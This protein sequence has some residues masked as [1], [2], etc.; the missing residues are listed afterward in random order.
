MRHPLALAAAR[1]V[2]ERLRQDGTELQRGLNLR[3]TAF[4]NRLN[5]IADEMQAPV[6]PKHFASWFM[7][8]LSHDAPLA[9]LF[10]AYMRHHGVHIWE[11]RPGFLT[12]AHSDA[13]LDRVAAA[14]RKVD[15]RDAARWLSAA[16]RGDAAG[17]RRPP[18]PRARTARWPKFLPDPVRPGK[19]LQL[20]LWSGADA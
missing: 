7:F 13:D 6:D 9:S 15:R 14:F 5:T 11:G 1:A 17:R 2:L 10:F 18:G 8:E 3:T 19:F 12:L 16:A 20:K 4:V